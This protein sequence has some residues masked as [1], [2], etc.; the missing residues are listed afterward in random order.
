MQGNVPDYNVEKYEAASSAVQISTPKDYERAGEVLVYLATVLKRLR[1]GDQQN[2]WVGWDQLV[3]DSKVAYDRTR[4]ARD[5]HLARWQRVKDAYE[6]AMQNF[7]LYEEQK[8]QQFTTVMQQTAMKLRAKIEKEGKEL[9]R[10]G[11]TEQGQAV[12]AQLEMM[13]LKPEP[14]PMEFRL[15]GIAQAQEY[16]VEITD[17][18]ELVKAVAQGQVPLYGIVQ[19]KRQALFDVRQSLIKLARA[20][21][22]EAFNWPGVKLKKKINYRPRA[23]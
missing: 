20:S 10:A 13:P 2:D 8:Q 21:M 18:M 15:T 19:K 9:M 16:D 17:L 14:T 6:K 23:V 1:E 11:L 3:S 7:R 5:K 22:G 12:L 4:E